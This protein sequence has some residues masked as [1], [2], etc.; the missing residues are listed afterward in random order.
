MTSIRTFLS[1]HYGLILFVIITAV[2]MYLR[3]WHIGN[4]YEYGFDQVRDA[5]KVRDILNGKLILD[6]PRT[7][8]GN[9]HIG[10][11]WYYYL[12]PFFWYTHRDP[13]ASMYANVPVNVFN[14]IALYWVSKR[15]FGQPF[16]WVSIFVLA[17]SRYLMT[18]TLVPWN[19]SPIIGV[20]ALIFYGIHQVVFENSRRW[21]PALMCL[22]GL[23]FHLHAAFVFVVGIVAVS[24]LVFAPDRRLVLKWA[25]FSLPLFLVWFVPIVVFN[26]SQV[27]DVGRLQGFVGGNF[28]SG[29]HLRLMARQATAA[30]A[31]FQVVWGLGGDALIWTRFVVPALFAVLV[32][33]K[34]NPNDKKLYWLLSIWFI[35]PVVA[36][37]LYTGPT[38]EYYVLLNAPMVIWI[39]LL[40]V[41]TGARHL[42]GLR[43]EYI[44]MGL[45]AVF[46]LIFA[47][48]ET[49]DIW[50]KPDYAGYWRQRDWAIDRVVRKKEPVDFSEG[51]LSSYVQ[52]LYK[53]D[54]ITLTPLRQW[55]PDR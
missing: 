23:F 7:G 35:V 2:G 41:R 54:H 45:V 46:L 4:S 12:A 25:L 28:I 29:I 30:L 8:V 17:V 38:S 39:C 44:A 5:W 9:F 34:R 51:D 40:L 48:R 33:R 26:L 20:S 55:T 3:F 53:E 16:A 36:Y 22:A 43:G 19:V 42:G 11:L 21:I 50:I 32:L 24:L 49:H 10:P 27:N 47:A 52:A 37:M 6:G 13:I 18:I 31:Q 1:R 14:F 15:I